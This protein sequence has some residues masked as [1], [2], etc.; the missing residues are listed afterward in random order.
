MILKNYWKWLE[1]VQKVNFW[2]SYSGDYNVGLKAVDGSNALILLNA[3]NDTNYFYRIADNHDLSKY[4]TIRLGSDDSEVTSD[5]YA[6]ENDV[7]SSISNYSYTFS[8]SADNG[9]SRIITIQGSN[10]G[11]QPITIK[12]VGICKDI[13]YIPSSY[14]QKTVMMAVHVLNEPIEVLPGNN[15]KLVFEWIEQ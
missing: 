13:W 14:A 9:V 2:Q 15:F 6:L 1:A 3:T 4:L 11:S 5:D 12:Q 10:C 7:T 8:S